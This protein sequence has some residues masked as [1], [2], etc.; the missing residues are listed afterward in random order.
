MVEPAIKPASAGAQEPLGIGSVVADVSPLSKE[1]VIAL[2][3]YAGAGCTTAGRRLEALLDGGGYRVHY[4]RLSE[5][6]VAKAP[7]G[8]V[9]TVESGLREG[10][11]K[12]RRAT[13]LQDVGDGLRKDFGSHAI[14]AL[15]IKAIMQMRGTADHGKQ[16]IAFILDSLKHSDEVNLLRKVY[17]LSFRLVAVHCERSRRE[18]RLIGRTASSAKFK[19]VSD[20]EVKGYMD[21]DEKDKGNRFG[22]QVRDAFYLADYFIDNNTNSQDG[23]RNNAELQRFIDLLLGN[24]LVRPTNAERGMFHAHAA[25]LQ[26]SCLSRQVGAALQAPD[27]RIIASGTND[28]PRF[29]GG[30]YSED[31]PQDHRC[32]VWEFSDGQITFR[33]CHNTRHKNRLRDEITQWFAD[34]FVG[35]LAQ[36]AHPLPKDG[37]DTAQ[38]AREEAEKRMKELISESSVKMDQI[39]GVKDL[40]EFSRSIHAEMDAVLNAART[41]TSPEGT[42]LY[43]TTFPCHSC[44]RQL[45]AAGVR[46]VL[47]IEPYVKSLAAE[48][49]SD[50]IQTEAPAV[51]SSGKGQEA[52]GMLILP[53]TG[54]GP[55]MYQDYFLKKGELKTDTGE[56]KAPVGEAPAYAVRL[57]EAAE[58]ETAAARLIPD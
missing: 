25:G 51:E 42:T 38:K 49:H 36:A 45:V 1:L 17:D 11:T 50:S 43:C 46:R 26:S 24:N 55:R 2:V 9:P 16:K 44:A 48:L 13:R 39:P 32:H 47:Y 12:F 29:G 28:V 4:I 58:V 57:R 3:G 14:A 35:L 10:P 33:G 5:L 22:Q 6:I 27:G 15:G 37:L 56:Y 18:L 40:I 23:F 21:R 52:K 53:F 41:G 30:V 20:A 19:G 7:I 31:T 34:T 54:V 8:T